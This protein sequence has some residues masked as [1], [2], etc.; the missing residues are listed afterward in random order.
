V[1]TD[2]YNSVLKAET[3]TYI[4]REENTNNV[5]TVKGS[6]RKNEYSAKFKAD[7]EVYPNGI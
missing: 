4:Q 7:F 5:K 3:S 2:V 6:N 1:T